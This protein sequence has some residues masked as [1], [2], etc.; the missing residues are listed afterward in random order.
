VVLGR[1]NW[2]FC[3]SDAGGT[4]AAILYSLVATCKEHRIEPWAYL[5]DVLGRISTHPNGRRA[6]LLPRNWQPAA[7]ATS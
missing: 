6:E 3:G 7:P 5:T 1:S 2:L 4:R